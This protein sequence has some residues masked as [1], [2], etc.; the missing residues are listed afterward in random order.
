MGGVNELGITTTWINNVNP[1]GFPPI[2]IPISFKADEFNGTETYFLNQILNTNSNTTYYLD[3]LQI[4]CPKFARQNVLVTLDKYKT[5]YQG[6]CGP[7]GQI[8]AGGL[9]DNKITVNQLFNGYYQGLQITN[10]NYN[11]TPNSYMLYGQSSGEQGTITYNAGPYKGVLTA[12]A[13]KYSTLNYGDYIYNTNTVDEK[14]WDKD[15]EG[16]V[17]NVNTRLSVGVQLQAGEY[18]AKVDYDISDN[19]IPKIWKTIEI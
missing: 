10:S 6:L 1:T 12:L 16:Y 18:V 14:K 5:L 7:Q 8:S 3:T 11:S 4:T 9:Y 2:I 17:S 19:T 15:V 13:T